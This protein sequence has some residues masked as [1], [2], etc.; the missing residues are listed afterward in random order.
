M[1]NNKNIKSPCVGKC[2]YDDAQICIACYRTK[3]E[4]VYWGDFSNN[5]KIKIIERVNKKMKK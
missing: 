1:D 3:Q 2:K 5:I 4:I